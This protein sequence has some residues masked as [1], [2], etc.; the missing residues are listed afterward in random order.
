MVNSAAFLPDA[1]TGTQ[2]DD[3]MNEA[4]INWEDDETVL[5]FTLD[6]RAQSEHG[7]ARLSRDAIDHVR[8]IRHCVDKLHYERRVIDSNPHH[9]N[10]LFRFDSGKHVD[11]MIANALALAAETI[12]RR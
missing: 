5:A 8:R 9:G 7:V 2:R 11:K 3:G 12:P 4:S 6:N 10:L 1:N